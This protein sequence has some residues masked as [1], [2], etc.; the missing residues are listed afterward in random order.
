MPRR[1]ELE[2]R[3]RDNLWPRTA[4]ALYQALQA[5]CDERLKTLASRMERRAN[6]EVARFEAI[7]DELAAAIRAQLEVMQTPRQLS[8]FDD[9]EREAFQADV[10]VLKERLRRI[11]GE[12][13]EESRHLRARYEDPRQTLFPLAVLWFV[14]ASLARA[15]M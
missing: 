9:E 5:R 3:L 12:K 2:E 7:M 8:L 4:P 14:P 6:E 15:G 13:A 11:P 1:E 10:A